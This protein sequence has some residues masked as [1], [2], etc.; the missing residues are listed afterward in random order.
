MKNEIQTVETYFQALSGGDFA[1]LGGLLDETTL[2]H[3]PGTGPLSGTYRGKDQIFALFGKFMEI[4]QGSFKIDGVDSIM[5]NGD[6]VT[7]TL[8]FSATKPGSKIAMAGVDL[9]KV[10]NGKLTEVHL[11]SSDQ[12]SE[13]AFWTAS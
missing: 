7:A 11:F 1:Q 5:V 13:D 9:M 8:R 12:V 10:K 4:S 2:W 6:L 3:Q